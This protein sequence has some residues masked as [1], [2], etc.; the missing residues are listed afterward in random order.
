MNVIKDRR[1]DQIHISYL[2]D[3][4][5]FRELYLS[6][7]D[8]WSKERSLVNGF[9][10]SDG[11]FVRFETPF[12]YIDGSNVLHTYIPDYQGN[13]VGVINT[14][15]GTLEQFTDYYPYGMPHTDAIGAENNRRKFVAKELTTEFGV[16]VYDFEHRYVSLLIPSFQSPDPLA[17]ETPHISPYSYCHGDPVNYCDPTGLYRSRE[18]AKMN[19]EIFDEG[20][21]IVFD[22]LREEWYIALDWTG[23]MPYPGQGPM[24][25]RY[26]NDKNLME[27]L[28]K[29]APALLTGT[30]VCFGVQDN[31]INKV[32]RETLDAATNKALK[33]TQAVTKAFGKEFGTYYKGLKLV[34]KG[35]T[36]AGVWM[37]INDARIYRINGGQNTWVYVKYACDAAF[38]ALGT[39]WIGM[40]LSIV[41]MYADYATDGFYI[42]YSIP[43]KKQ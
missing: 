6:G 35:V 1:G 33:D 21:E 41:Y 15:D 14:S 22:P 38:S 4:R 8:M 17:Y 42:D 12:G 16:D 34:G 40:G 27:A 23:T 9:E 2:A 3:G 18:E 31:L 39:S 29:A 13:I 11:R 20:V 24:T 5:K 28:D 32:A 25:K 37:A 43:D 36:V 10:F 30:S 7:D 26:G 19:E